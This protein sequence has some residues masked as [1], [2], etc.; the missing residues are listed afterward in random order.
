VR[1]DAGDVSKTELRERRTQPGVG[2]VAGVSG[3]RSES[4]N[5]RTSEISRSGLFGFRLE[6]DRTTYTNTWSR[7][8]CRTLK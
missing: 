2:A 5:Q 6:K 1:L 7:T 4:E 8:K 3:G